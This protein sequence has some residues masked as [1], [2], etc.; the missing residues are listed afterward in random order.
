LKYIEAEP[1]QEGEPLYKVRVIIPDLLIRSGPG[2]AYAVVQR[3][4]S[5]EYA[6]LEER[7]GYGRVGAGRWISLDARYV[8]RIASAPTPEDGVELTM[9]EKVDILWGWY[10][11]SK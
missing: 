7:S 5:G 10:E 2:K 11:E 3:Y 8:E 6:V 1:I 4:A 9:G